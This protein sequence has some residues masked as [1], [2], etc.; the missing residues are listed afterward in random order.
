VVVVNLK[1]FKFMVPDV[2]RSRGKRIVSCGN[3]VVSMWIYM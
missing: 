3:W 2:N 1:S